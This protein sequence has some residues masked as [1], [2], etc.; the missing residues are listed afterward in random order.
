M[1]AE[2]SSL[3][4]SDWLSSILGPVLS[5]LMSSPWIFIP[6]LCLLTYAMRYVIVSAT[7][8]LAVMVAI[9]GPVML[10]R[11]MSL[12]PL[13]FVVYTCGGLWNVAY[14][15]PMPLAAL[16]A[17]GGKFVTFNE[18]RFGSYA[19]CIASLIGMTACVP[20]WVYLGML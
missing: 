16:A 8:N 4:V 13:V 12:F 11:D 20:V 2:M 6:V 14:Q 17:S 15:N 10:A 1:A 9:F 7:A 5:P 3:F 18:F 19:Y